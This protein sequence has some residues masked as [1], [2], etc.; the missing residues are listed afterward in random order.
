MSSDIDI[1]ET[2]DA[3]ISLEVRARSIGI[4]VSDPDENAIIYFDMTNAEH[5]AGLKHAR[6]LRALAS[7]MRAV[8][9]RGNCSRPLG[10]LGPA[11]YAVRLCDVGSR[12]GQC[13]ANPGGIF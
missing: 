13:G 7:R 5:R 12:S 6:C 8:W 4:R 2:N 1:L 10:F 11:G 9:V 3:G